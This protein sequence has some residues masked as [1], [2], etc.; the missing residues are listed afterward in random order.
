LSTISES[1]VRSCLYNWLG[2]GKL[3]SHVWIVGVEEGVLEI[4]SGK[5]TLESSLSI[6]ST[7]P[8]AMDFREVWE[9]RFG[10]RPIKG[11][12]PWNFSA[13]FLLEL[14][15][16]P[17]TDADVSS[18]VQNELGRVNSDHFLCEFL[19]L[20]KPGRLN[21]TGYERVW[22]N[23]Q[24]YWE[25]VSGPRIRLIEKTLLEYPEVKLLITYDWHFSSRVLE[26]FPSEQLQQ[27]KDG[28]FN[29]Y[30]I[31]LNEKRNIILLSTP[32]W[33]QGQM[34]KADVPIAVKYIQEY[35]SVLES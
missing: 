24:S 35:L 6:R 1:L 31:N 4:N 20:P 28:K 27:W 19:P 14:K 12:S 23:H 2:Y 34:S 3:N 9:D 13:R 7:F 16:R 29:L 5:Q 18:F 30:R 8:L 15:N 32:F 33:G 21:M 22:T 11:S 26:L 17:A 10:I 25:E